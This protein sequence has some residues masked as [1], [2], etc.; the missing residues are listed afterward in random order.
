MKVEK[1]ERLGKIDHWFFNR[2]Q[3]LFAL[4]AVDLICYYTLFERPAGFFQRLVQLFHKKSL[5]EYF[6]LAISVSSIERF[7]DK[8]THYLSD[9]VEV[10]APS[11]PTALAYLQPDGSL[12]E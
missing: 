10:S 11:S 2:Q 6:V 4:L 9:P 3:A 5:Q 7:V 12:H 1:E 8:I